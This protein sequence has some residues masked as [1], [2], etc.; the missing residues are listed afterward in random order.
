[1]K[2][3]AIILLFLLALTTVCYGQSGSSDLLEIKFKK[4]RDDIYLAYRPET[5]RYWVEGN[6]SSPRSAQSVI[7]Q[8]RKL[9]NKPVRYLINPLLCCTLPSIT[10][11]STSLMIVIMLLGIAF[12]VT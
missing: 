1:M 3:K 4:L 7:A 9:T 10:T 11:T 8:I 5:L 6:V 2:S 12:A